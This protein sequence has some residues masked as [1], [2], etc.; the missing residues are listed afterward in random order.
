MTTIDNHLTTIR[1]P[2]NQ[3][4][5]LTWNTPQFTTPYNSHQELERLYPPS[6]SVLTT[7]N[8]TRNTSFPQICRHAIAFN[9]TIT[10]LY[11]QELPYQF[12]I[13][14]LDYTDDQLYSR[15]TKS[16]TRMVF[17]FETFNFYILEFLNV[18]N[19]YNS[20]DQILFYEKLHQYSYVYFYP[21]HALN[22]NKHHIFV[23]NKFSSP[24]SPSTQY[25]LDSSYLHGRIRNYDPLKDFYISILT[26]SPILP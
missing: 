8:Q 16:L 21:H 2:I 23:N 10:Q 26:F 3:R 15:A 19:N 11:M 12:Q 7:L 25:Y 9:P 20:L 6:L 5:T 17:G 22:T 1:T 18:T 14:A 4:L 13:P 24:Y